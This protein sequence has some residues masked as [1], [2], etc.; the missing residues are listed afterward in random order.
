ML[1]VRSGIKTAIDGVVFAVFLASRL[2]KSKIKTL[3]IAFFDSKGVIH[4]EF[5]PGGQTI[6]A[7]FFQAVLNRLLQRIRQVR[8]ELHRT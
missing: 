4:M 5:V 8:P 1:S 7:A 6:N 3:L 2:Q